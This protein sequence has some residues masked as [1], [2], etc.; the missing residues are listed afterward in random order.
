MFCREKQGIYSYIYLSQPGLYAEQKKVK[1]LF[2]SS[3]LK[4]WIHI[5]RLRG[6]IH[7]I[8]WPK[9][10]NQNTKW[11]SVGSTSRYLAEANINLLWR[12]VF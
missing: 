12:N 9:K 2:K 1:N 4:V 10:P 6:R 11:V 8:F 5:G 7:A 3:S